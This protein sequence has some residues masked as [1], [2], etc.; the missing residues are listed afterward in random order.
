ELEAEVPAA[1][2]KTR[3]VPVPL[4]PGFTPDPRPMRARPLV[5]MQGSTPHK[6]IAAQA[7]ALAGLPVDT[8]YIGT[9]N[10][11]AAEALA[12]IG[13]RIESGLDDATMLARYRECDLLLFASLYEGYGMPIV[14]AQAIGRPVVTSDHGATREVAGG[15]AILVDPE[16]VES[17]RAGVQRVIEDHAERERIVAAGFV[18]AE[19]T[20]VERVA[21]L[22][23]AAYAEA[24]EAR[25]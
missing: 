21:A 24:A 15:A 4:L 16:S 7:R 1:R 19:R 12:A 20:T 10:A 14:E 13:A 6:N 17:I 22:Y 9:P 18:N 25:R 2:G 5:L 3:T 11:E 8:L 23:R